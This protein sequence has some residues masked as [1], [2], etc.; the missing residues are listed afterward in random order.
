[1]A[2]I[3]FG[4]VISA[5]RRE[6]FMTQRDLAGQVKRD[7]VPISPAYLNDIEHDRRSPSPEL[8]KQIAKV[9]GIPEDY[10]TYLAGRFPDGRRLPQDQFMEGMRAFRKTIR[11]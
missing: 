8:I 10:L 9:L 11:G 3:T 1:M 7:G 4:S 2:Q 6:L 5:K